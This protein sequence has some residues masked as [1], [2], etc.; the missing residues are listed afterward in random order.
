LIY[1]VELLIIAIIS[2]VYFIS[3]DSFAQK[4]IEPFLPSNA[5][6]LNQTSSDVNVSQKSLYTLLKVKNSLI[7]ADLSTL[8]TKRCLQVKSISLTL[9]QTNIED[10]LNIKPND[11]TSQSDFCVQI[12]HISLESQEINT[13][14][15]F[16]RPI[17]VQIDNLQLKQSILRIQKIYADTQHIDLTGLNLQD[18]DAV[19]KDIVFQDA[20]LKARDVQA[21][22]N[23]VEDNTTYLLKAHGNVQNSKLY[24]SAQTAASVLTHFLPEGMNQDAFKPL[25]ANFTLNTQGLDGLIH[26]QSTNMFHN[27]LAKYNVQAEDIQTHLKLNFD[28]VIL[29]LHSLAHINTTLGD[30]VLT[31]NFI[32]QEPYFF[33]GNV[34]SSNFN[35]T[36]FDENV[37]ASYFKDSN[38][39]YKWNVDALSLKYKQKQLEVNVQTKDYEKYDVRLHL[40]P[41]KISAFS[42]VKSDKNVTLDGDFLVDSVHDFVTNGS[43]ILNVNNQCQIDAN[44]HN[45][46]QSLGRLSCYQSVLPVSFKHE[47]IFPL[48]F[49]AN[50]KNALDINV[51]H[52]ELFSHIHY[53]RAKEIATQVKLGSYNFDING[54]YKRGKLDLKSKN[55]INSCQKFYK[56][57]QNYYKLDDLDI[58]CSAQ[59]D[60]NI[61]GTFQQP[62]YNVKGVLKDLTV[63]KEESMNKI[64]RFDFS[65]SGYDNKMILD[66]YDLN[67]AK[68]HIYATAPS[69]FEIKGNKI[70]FD[71][72]AVY[73]KKV[74]SGWYDWKNLTAH[75]TL[76]TQDFNYASKELN[77]TFDSN[78]TINYDTTNLDIRG[79]VDLKKTIITYDVKRQIDPLDKDII[80]IQEEQNPSWLRRFLIMDITLK[81][82]GDLIYKND[83][84]ELVMQTDLKIKK[85][86]YYKVRPVGT[87][88]IKR[89][90]YDGFG[91]TFRI[92]P[93]EVT[94]SDQKEF[95]P[96]LN[97]YAEVKT[98]EALIDINLVGTLNDPEIY[99]SSTPA[100]DE[101]DILSLI[102]FDSRSS[103]FSDSATTNDT[104]YSLLS[105]STIFSEDFANRLG[106]K[107]NRL[108]VIQT[109]DGKTG[110]EVGARLNS[111]VSIGYISD[112]HSRARLQYDLSDNFALD[113]ESGQD[114]SA[115]DA[116]FFMQY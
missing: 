13:S 64:N 17:R 79:N 82:S 109:Q 75:F 53:S 42:N 62:N 92:Q 21:H 85:E 16:F 11:A 71:T 24:F 40:N 32:L 14:D 113:V 88:W 102:L 81:N 112:D 23:Y 91:R 51:T 8:F 67:S 68:E 37:K 44:I 41:E 73:D 39:A 90:Y 19:A 103:S 107:I 106:L 100:M 63:S 116:L 115:V 43:Y 101:T 1:L 34:T 105:M 94:F 78:L 60:V 4:Y 110:F 26:S 9:S 55:R 70:L 2:G 76:N 12:K 104:K 28:D 38:I 66:S 45:S 5:Q 59:F 50:Y 10:F 97:I 61:N 65:L 30:F 18:I 22:L 56:N 29:H 49:S 80:I 20:K 48:V 93:S 35:A 52:N 72:L 95:N 74:G 57:I 46:F 96:Y 27:A 77:T 31:H 84:S 47:K 25:D 86:K 3:S 7:D 33:D 98:K 6:E 111:K 58:N 114:Y 69:L 54:S 87:L 36:H 83:N 15:V 108:N 99:F 89:G